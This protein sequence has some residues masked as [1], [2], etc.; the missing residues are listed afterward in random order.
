M[1]EVGDVEIYEV[2]NIHLGAEVPSEISV[3]DNVIWP[4]YNNYVITFSSYTQ[5]LSGAGNTTATIPS[6]NN[7]ITLSSACTALSLNV[8]SV[9]ETA[10]GGGVKTPFTDDSGSISWMNDNAGYY[11]VSKS[12]MA[13]NGLQ[14]FYYTGTVNTSMSARV[15]VIRFEQEY[16]GNQKT[17]TVNQ[18]CKPVPNL[19]TGVSISAIC[20]DYFIGS[21]QASTDGNGIP[22]IVIVVGSMKE[23][24]TAN[25]AVITAEYYV[26]PYQNPGPGSPTYTTITNKEFEIRSNT[27][28]TIFGQKVY[29]VT[30]VAGPRATLTSITRFDVY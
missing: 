16:G 17:L 28:N 6:T 19:P 18:D 10:R 8:Y 26:W 25:T 5:T 29:A 22:I 24:N 11:Y 23:P 14:T 20:G 9:Y 21:Y 1:I 13:N 3:G 4:E 7:N 2:N 27:T 30:I 15:N 12:S